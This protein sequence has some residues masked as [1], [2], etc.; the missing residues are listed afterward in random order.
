MTD[1]KTINTFQPESAK[2]VY[3]ALIAA[4]TAFDKAEDYLYVLDT[5]ALLKTYSFDSDSFNKL[6]KYFESNKGKIFA[7]HYVEIEYIRN[8]ES[9]GNSFAV[10]SKKK[11]VDAFN[12]IGKAINSLYSNAS[13]DYSY[14]MK[15]NKELCEKIKSLN[16]NYKEVSND[17]A[18]YEKN[19]SEDNADAFKMECFRMIVENV[20]FTTSLTKDQYAYLKT[21]FEELFKKSKDKNN[22]E[23][24]PIFPG[25]GE[26]KQINEYGDYLIFHE[27]LEMA[28]NKQKNIILLTNDVA[29]NDWVDKSGKTFESYQIM[30]YAVTNK[31]FIVQKYDDFLKNIIGIDAQVLVESEG[32][33][34][35]LSHEDFDNP[36]AAIEFLNLY[37]VLERRLIEFMGRKT[38]I[39]TPR[40][41]FR[42]YRTYIND[43]LFKKY[44]Y[45]ALCRNYFILEDVSFLNSEDINYDRALVYIKELIGALP[46][47][48][49]A[50]ARDNRASKQ[51][52]AQN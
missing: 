38:R 41:F 26:K 17:V 32:S 12:E 31:S 43:D 34:E 29:K 25:R 3:D 45:I 11:F 51:L 42:R 37:R 13:F 16:D 49:Q 40:L 36:L 52:F 19:I 1:F 24:L 15:D 50:I 10:V 27:L 30:F 46:I 44:E 33:A 28:K 35:Q 5:N 47:I 7:T 48:F 39:D 22:K 14:L 4:K 9:V 23:I 2:Q 8:R 18:K 20:D 21:E 6:K